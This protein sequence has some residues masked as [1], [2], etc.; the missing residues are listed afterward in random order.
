[1]KKLWPEQLYRLNQE[2][3]EVLYQQLLPVFL[4]LLEKENIPDKTAMTSAFND[5]YLPFA[6]WLADK[7]QAQPLVIGINGAQG[8][9]KSTLSQILAV[10][11]EKG[12]AKKVMALSIDDLY[13]TRKQRQHLAKKIH[14]LLVTRGVPGTHDIEVGLKLFSNLLDENVS[15]DIALPKFDKAL[16]DRL[17]LEEWENFTL[18]VDIVLFEGWCVGS[19]AEDETALTIDVNALEANEDPDKIWRQYVNQQLSS[20][21]QELFSYID[22]LVMLQIPG[23]EQ[24][25]EWRTLQEQKLAASK[26]KSKPEKNQHIMSKAQLER[27]IMHYERLTRANLKEMPSRADIVMKLN[28]NHQVSEV[29]ARIS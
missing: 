29:M 28:E 16:D 27:F 3:Y 24:V 7:H 2:Q 21:Y 12:F 9:G 20:S 23:M 26:A 6:A 17:P 10:L 1:M 13:K 11:L 25:N 18:P 4:Q 8:S 15:E 14:P 19:I 22:I 5:L